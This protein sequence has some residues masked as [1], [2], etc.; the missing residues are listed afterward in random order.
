MSVSDENQG[1]SIDEPIEKEEVLTYGESLHRVKNDP[2]KS[3]NIL[4]ILNNKAITAEL[5]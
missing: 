5:L 3:L 1:Q 2:Q 4:K